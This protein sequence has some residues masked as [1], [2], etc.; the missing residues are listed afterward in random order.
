M[1]EVGGTLA[2]Y[3]DPMSLDSIEGAVMRLIGDHRYREERAAAIAGADLRTWNDV[4]DD[5]WGLL[6][7]EGSPSDAPPSSDTTAR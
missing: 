3:A 1:P 5:L 4:A 7:D 2:D 6:A